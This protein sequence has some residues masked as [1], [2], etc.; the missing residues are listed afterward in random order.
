MK[1]MLNIVITILIF[2]SHL[3]AQE[4]N[5]ELYSDRYD[6]FKNFQIKTGY[7]PNKHV[8]NVEGNYSLPMSHVFAFGVD[9]R[10][11]S[12]PTVSPSIGTMPIILS[13]RFSVSVKGGLEFFIFSP[14]PLLNVSTQF[15]GLIRYKVH[16]DYNLILEFKQIN[17]NS[18]MD[19]FDTLLPRIK[20]LGFPIQFI[21]L[22]IEL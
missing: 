6:L 22:G 16:N 7:S 20:V 12:F 2:S 4:S 11:Y 9:F 13:D 1:K 21:S 10:L 8:V 17:Q 14:L 3:L 19:G 15:S 5:Q 18:S